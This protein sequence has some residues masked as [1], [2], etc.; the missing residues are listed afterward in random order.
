MRQSMFTP[1]KYKDCKVTWVKE[2]KIKGLEKEG[3]SQV[4]VVFH[5]LTLLVIIPK[6]KKVERKV[7]KRKITVVEV[8]KTNK[9]KFK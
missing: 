9:K 3:F 5:E 1:D 8:K 7:I 6:P 4:G 2:E